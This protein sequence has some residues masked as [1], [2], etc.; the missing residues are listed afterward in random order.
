MKEK[1]LIYLADLTHVGNVIC[2][3]VFP[4]S[5]GLVGAYLQ[6]KMMDDVK[7][8]LFKFPDDLSQAIETRLPQIV[9]FT[10]YSWNTNLAYGFAMRIKEEHPEVVIVFGGPNYGLTDEEKGIFWDRYPLVDFYIAYE[11]E[12]AMASLVEQLIVYDFDVVRLKASGKTLPNCHYLKEGKI[13]TSENCPRIKDASEI[14]SPYLMGLMDK[15]FDHNLIP[16]TFTTRGCPFRCTYCSEGSK[17]YQKVIQRTDLKDELQYIATRI[18]H[19]PVLYL[20]DANFGM[21]REDVDKARLIAKIQEQYGYPTTLLVATGK[22]QKDRVLEVAKILKGA[23]FISTALQTTDPEVLRNVNRENLTL[24]DLTELTQETK[25]A[26]EN[27][28]TE[29]IL[30][31]PGDTYEKHKKSLKDT[32]ESGQ[33]VVRMYQLIMLQQTEL[34]VPGN[35]RK[36]QLKT[37]YRITPRSYGRYRVFGKEFTCVEAEKICVGNGTMSYEEYLDCRELDMTVEILHNGGPFIDFWYLCQWLDY[38]WFDFLMKFHAQRKES[39]E[40]IKELYEEFRKDTM[41]GYW[42]TY[43]DLQESV[44]GKFDEYVG[45][46]EGTNEMSKAKAVAFFK[47]EEKLH[48]ILSENMRTILIE[49]GQWDE[50]I[51]LY[52][53]ELK[54]FCKSR[55]SNVFEFSETIQQEFNFDFISLMHILKGVDPSGFKLLGPV[56]YE[57]FITDKQKKI[58]GAYVDLYGKN[59]IDGLGRILMRSRMEDLFREVRQINYLPRVVSV[60]E[61][62]S[63]K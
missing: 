8:E 51:R 3:E 44:L 48:E 56:R 32:V 31:L 2:S 21:W 59:S 16:L 20:S 54:R 39:G 37:R 4:L 10:I 27:T 13:I 11:G 25:K 35:I 55:K 9:G 23:M 40:G 61:I 29:L 52:L 38:P 26:G 62:L 15:F 14:P 57:F 30:A 60:D 5:V 24:V 41:N 46:V 43:E 28:Y 53:E 19:T 63:G 34:N 18:K 22:N 1:T 49:K 17:Y 6:N 47:L 50:D 45:N 7:V 12:V 36:Y 42:D 33:G 58:F